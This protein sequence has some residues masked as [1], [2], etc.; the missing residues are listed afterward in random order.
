MP[1]FTTLTN[2]AWQDA[3]GNP[4]AGGSLVLKLSSDAKLSS[5]GQ[6]APRYVSFTLDNSGNL[7]GGATV[8]GND[9]LTPAGTFYI[10]EVLNS[11]GSRVW[12]PQNWALVA[13]TTDAG[14]IVPTVIGVSYPNPV[15]LSPAAAQAGNISVTGTINSNA[16]FLLNGS[17]L[18][19]GATLQPNGVNNSSQSVLNLTSGTGV[20]VTNTSGGIDQIALSGAINLAASGAG[21]VTGNLPVGNLN[22]GTGASSSTFWRGDTFN[23][24]L[25]SSRRGCRN[26]ATIT[27]SDGAVAWLDSSGQI[28]M[29]DGSSL[30]ELGTDIRPD[31]AGLN[32]TL[33][34]MTFHVASDKHWLVFSTGNKIFV[35]DADTNQWMPPWSFSAQ[36]L[37]SGEVS[38]GVY[39]LQ[40]STGTK[41]VQLSNTAHNNQSATYLPVLRTNSFAMVPDF[42]TSFS[43]AGL[44]TYDEPSRT[45]WPAYFQVDTNANPITDVAF[46]ADDDATDPTLSYTS[47]FVA[48]TTPQKAWNR[49][50]GSKLVQNVFAMVKPT[51]RWIS[52]QIKGKQVD[53]ALRICGYFL[54]YK[55]S[56]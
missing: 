1:V 2:G 34:S 14:T 21:G 17:P 4:I 25:I 23:R 7:P 50:Q 55:E 46:L 9:Q 35:Y 12:G 52:Y 31:L 44:G 47:I 53:D 29:S 15:L 40:A 32:P 37:Y 5:N 18:S 54:A 48:Q 39:K 13:G 51:A 3:H 36:Y 20:S 6:I 43:A 49:G 42:G 41:A 27:H 19:P 8:Y 16:G 38:P 10:A 56:K 26:L 24:F 45:G 22:S 33:C 30:Q 28:W 11:G